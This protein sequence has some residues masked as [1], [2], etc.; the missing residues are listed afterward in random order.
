MSSTHLDHP[1]LR[2]Y[3]VAILLRSGSI[4]RDDWRGIL[5]SFQN[6]ALALYDCRP[7]LAA[8]CGFGPGLLVTALSIAIVELFFHPA[9]FFLSIPHANVILLAIVGVGASAVLGRLQT[10]NAALKRAKNAISS[11]LIKSC[12]SHQTAAQSCSKS[13]NGSRMRWRTI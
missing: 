3:A 5:A 4:S 13:C 7:A 6:T 10:A 2:R 11:P 12:L 1:P 8:L 9:M